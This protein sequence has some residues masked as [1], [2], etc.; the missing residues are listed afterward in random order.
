VVRNIPSTSLRRRDD[1]SIFLARILY[2]ATREKVSLAILGPS[3]S[4]Q[5]HTSKEEDAT[6]GLFCAGHAP[7]P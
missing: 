2:R 3:R 4:A 5:W 1:R 7:L 6:C